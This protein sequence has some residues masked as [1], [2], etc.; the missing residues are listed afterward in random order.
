MS[1]VDVFLIHGISKSVN[2]DHYYDDFVDGL[3]KYMPRVNGEVVFHGIDYSHLLADKEDA[4]YSWMSGMGYKRIRRF[5]CDFIGDVLAYAWPR[6]PAQSGDFI[7]D[8]TEMLKARFAEAPAGSKKVIIGHSLGTIVGYGAS[9]DIPIDAL[10]TMGSPFCYFSVRYRNFGEM[11]PDLKY[12]V[13]YYR[14]ND[15]VSTIIG[16]NPNF[17]DH[18]KDIRVGSWN[19]LYHLGGLYSAVKNH[20][21][22]Y[23]KS[24]QVHEDIGKRLYALTLS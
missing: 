13:N 4:I 8:L 24:S 18:V 16:N 14:D 2:P 19:P 10:F 9:W 3:R 22:G 23:W 15:I 21:D 11:N 17:S 7:Y 5:A 20:T 1:R 6:R 12:W